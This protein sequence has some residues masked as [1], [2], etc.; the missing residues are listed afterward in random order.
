MLFYFNGMLVSL[1]GCVHTCTAAS[2][3]PDESFDTLELRLQV[4]Y[5][6]E[7]PEAGA[8]NENS[9]PLQERYPYLTAEPSHRTQN[10]FQSNSR[11][12]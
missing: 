12:V 5:R 8:G 4:V 6:G 1:D 11:G 7:P 9:G 2:G 3:S 10:L